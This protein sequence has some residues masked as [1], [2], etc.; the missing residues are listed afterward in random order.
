MLS[1]AVIW[2]QGSCSSEMQMFW[3]PG[4]LQGWVEDRTFCEGAEWG[5]NS[6]FTEK[7]TNEKSGCAKRESSAK[8]LLIFICVSSSSL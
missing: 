5:I 1:C 7:H 6:C 2:A 8:L 3:P 4:D